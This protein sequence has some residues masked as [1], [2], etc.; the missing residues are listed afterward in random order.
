MYHPSEVADRTLVSRAT[1]RRDV[2]ME[3]VVYDDFRHIFRYKT[4]HKL[5]CKLSFK[6]RFY[7]NGYLVPLPANRM[8]VFCHKDHKG[9]LNCLLDNFVI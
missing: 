5:H 3:R 4:G 6:E 9:G 2:I 1:V 8:P 7:E